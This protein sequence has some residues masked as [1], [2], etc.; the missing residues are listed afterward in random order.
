MANIPYLVNDPGHPLH[1][2]TIYNG[3]YACITAIILHFSQDGSIRI[4]VNKRGSGCSTFSG[5]WNIPCGFLEENENGPQ[6]AAREVYEENGVKIPFER[7][8]YYSNNLSDDPSYRFK[9]HA[10]SRFIAVLTDKDFE[11]G[12][13]DLSHFNEIGT[14]GGEKDEVSIRKWIRLGM[15]DMYDWA[16]DQKQVLDKLCEDIHNGVIKNPYK[17]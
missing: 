11:N 13:I 7:F 2:Q 12:T 3:C 15:H 5:K 8:V 6:C 4:L 14:T 16:F 10:V 9:G 17:S 1:G